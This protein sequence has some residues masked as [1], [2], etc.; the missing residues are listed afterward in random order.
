[1]IDNSQILTDLKRHLL[2]NYGKSIKN[3][4]LFAPVSSFLV[5]ADNYRG[6]FAQG[7]EAYLRI[8]LSRS[9]SF[10]GSYSFT[11][12]QFGEPPMPLPGHPEHRGSAR[13]SWEYWLGKMKPKLINLVK[14]NKDMK[15]V[16]DIGVEMVY[17]YKSNDGNELARIT[18]S[19][20]DYK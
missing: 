7:L 14:T 4:I 9:L 18:L 13:L 10:H 5:R 20:N 12:T 17:I 16:R 2:N 1:M 11:Q 19:P 8:G 15:A 3:I 6:A